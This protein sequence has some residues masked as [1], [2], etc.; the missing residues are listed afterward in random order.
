MWR[1]KLEQLVGLLEKI[2]Q[3]KS[4]DSKAGVYEPY[5][6]IELR[7]SNWELVPY[8]T[9]TRLDGSPGREVR[10]TMQVVDN[11]KVDIRQAEL[12]ALNF[13]EAD[14]AANSRSIFSYTQ[15]VG[16]LLDW[17][18]DS[19]IV[20]KESAYKDPEAVTVAPQV[21][22]IILRLKNSENGFTL[23]PSLAF[24]DRSSIDIEGGAVILSANPVYL[25]YKDRLYKINSE[26]PAVFW[27]NYF[28]IREQFVIPTEELGEFIRLYLPHLLPVLDWQNLGDHI[29]QERQALTDKRIVFSEANHHLQIEVNFRYGSAAFPAYPEANRS[30]AH[31]GESLTIIVR[32]ESAERAARQTL[33]EH[34]LLFRNGSW[35]IAADYHPLDWM[36]TIVPELEAA[37]FTIEGE[38]A[39]HRYRVHRQKPRIQIKVKSGPAWMDLNYKVTIGR[40]SADIPDLWR[41][42]ESGRPYLRLADGSHV[43]LTDDVAERLRA[44]SRYLDLNDGSGKSR[45]PMAGVALLRELEG[46]SDQFRLDGSAETLLEKYRRFDS[47]EAIAP[48][49]RLRGTL[50]E[51]QQHG[52]DWLCFLNMFG[53]GGIL[54]DDMG[55]GKTV[56]V[57]SLLLHRKERREAEGPSLIV[58]PLTLLFN[59]QEELAKFAPDL[60]V[61]VYS[62]NRAERTRLQ[63]AFLSHDVVLCSYGV[64]LQDQR[65]LSAVEFEYL[66]LD[67]SQKI[68]NPQTKTYKAVTRLKSRFRLAMT[69]TPVENALTD[70]WAQVNFT[71][72]GLLG[73][74]KQFQAHYVDIPESEQST[75]L[76][77]LKKIIY[78]FILRRTKE[79]VERE[80]PP[81]TEIVQYIEMSESQKETY[82]SSVRRFREQIFAEIESRGIGQARIKIVEALTYLRQIACHPAILDD[83]VHLEDSGKVQLLVD[84]IE[85]LIERGHKILIFSQFVRFLNLIRRLFE[86]RR[87]RYEYLDGKVRDRAERIHNFQDN[88][89]IAAFLI[90]LKAGG[91]GLN[92]TAADYVIHLD[93]WWNPAVEQQATDRAH[94]IGQDKNVFVYKYI[95]RDTVEEK[96][97]TLQARKKALSEELITSDS[98]FVK[99]LTR[100][101]LEVLFALHGRNGHPAE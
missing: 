65:A 18:G 54:A 5:F 90:S 34:G 92:L 91:L 47:I 6:V 25:I 45:L 17:L 3:P 41:Q 57:I 50:R 61:M 88:P 77:I 69:G 97:L 59:W 84:M 94:R 70:L 72:P 85:E 20:V 9:Y 40:E 98:G 78:P 62:G 7:A 33:E 32:D 19:R 100:E 2:P 8:A 22:K 42:L 53:F 81:L 12:D 29:E 60:T 58:V 76:A 89:D 93:P 36:R 26:M 27:H 73:T 67:E 21:G 95:V 68:K 28:R 83:S 86:E 14:A 52:L 35:S 44:F 1:H 43:Y 63:K 38:E 49:A 46:V 64:A 87:W 82:E 101:D 66:I 15:P 24:A 31:E 74:L 11:S 13:L 48:P 4:F 30:L 55:L 37:G 99:S 75:Q 16:F 79:E 23:Q 96:I 56:Q 80:L 51:Y 10:L 71:N 39:L